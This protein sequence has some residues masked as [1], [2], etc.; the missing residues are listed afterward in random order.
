MDGGRFEYADAVEALDGA[1]RFGIN[2]SLEGIRTLAATLGNPQNAYRAVQVT[3]TNG[4]TSV[5]R[6]VG[7][8][9]AA[10]GERVGV[11]TSPHLVSYAERMEVAGVPAGEDAF[12]EAV[13]AALR[14]ADAIVASGHEQPGSAHE[15]LPE[16]TEF[17]L[18]TAAALWLF[19]AERVEWAVLEVGMGGRWDA[20]SVVNPAVSVITGVGLD[21]TDR[22]GTTREEIAADKAY[23]IK[24]GCVAVLGP[25]CAGVEQVLL[26]RALAMGVPTVH[27]GEAEDDVAWRIRVGA[28]APGGVTHFDVDGAL[29]RYE[30][31]AIAAPAF[32]VPN[33]ATAI[34]AAEAALAGPLDPAA[35][36][37]AFADVRFPGRFERLRQRP[38]L[39]IDGA[40]NPQAAAV[41]ADAIAATFPAERP[42]IVLGVLAD[43][44]A[45]GIVAALAP[46]AARFVV[47]RPG[48]PRALAVAELAAIVHRATGD[49]PEQQPD[50][51][52]ALQAVASE[53]A[54]VTGSLY[55][56]GEA[57][58]L[59]LPSS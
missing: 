29:E 12:A 5:T 49:R 6:M 37:R 43:K 56:A 14:A 24:P 11:Y 39:V 45:A 17:E 15:P 57:R 34:A 48:S 36:R 23:V 20:T 22:L 16:F 35:V 26:D 8:L 3:G 50:V 30:G 52:A 9:L 32:Q 46:V 25:G 1:L 7:A 33:A 59:L 55:T 10:H 18:L 38:P 4:K 40:H 54:V 2:P 44:D 21:H 42:T 19:R 51:A 47:T 28:R 13:A 58:A 41:L 53:P 27:V 31:L